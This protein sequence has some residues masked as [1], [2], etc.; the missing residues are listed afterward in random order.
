MSKGNINII[1]DKNFKTKFSIS[2]LKMLLTS[3][4][5]KIKPQYIDETIRDFLNE[6]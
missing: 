2:K 5:L 6:K 4:Q 3:N 1:K